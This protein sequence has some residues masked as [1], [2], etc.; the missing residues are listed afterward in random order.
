MV[1][2]G[3]DYRRKTEQFRGKKHLVLADMRG[4]KTPH[5]D[6]ARIMGETIFHARS[7]GA[8]AYVAFA[9]EF[10]S[11]RT[12]VAPAVVADAPRS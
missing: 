4:M 8:E 12:P 7:R 10:M 11:R 2:W 3:D 6:V 9:R 5:P 1:A